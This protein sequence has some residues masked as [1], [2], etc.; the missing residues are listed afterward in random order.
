MRFRHN[1]QQFDSSLWRAWC[2]NY[3]T[4][5]LNHQTATNKAVK[6]IC[7]SFNQPEIKNKSQTFSSTSDAFAVKLNFLLENARNEITRAPSLLFSIKMILF[8]AQISP[9]TIDNCFLA[10][11]IKF[12]SRHQIF[13][14]IARRAE[15]TAE[16][17]SFHHSPS[18]KKRFDVLKCERESFSI[19]HDA[20][21][22]WL[23]GYIIDIWNTRKPKHM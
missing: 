1:F 21:A 5:R 11:L 16:G 20:S 4:T 2:I 8:T 12:K 7:N 13:I 23:K 6:A 17:F 9:P 3:F 19:F 14:I 22:N 18:R 15:H 10:I